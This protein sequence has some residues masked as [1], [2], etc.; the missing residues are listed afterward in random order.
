MSLI[1]NHKNYLSNL[2]TISFIIG[3]IYAFFNWLVMLFETAREGNLFGFVFVF[4]LQSVLQLVNA[5][6]I[7][8]I[9]WVVLLI[10]TLV[11]YLV[12]RGVKSKPVNEQ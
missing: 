11:P 7:A 2:W 6:I 5:L 3:G 8:A 4:L 9:L 1:D 10:L 12:W